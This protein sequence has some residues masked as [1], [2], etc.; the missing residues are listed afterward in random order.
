MCL[1]T[2]NLGMHLIKPQIWQHFEGWVRLWEQ[3]RSI[4]PEPLC[5]LIPGFFIFHLI[6]AARSSRAQHH[7]PALIPTK[8]LTLLAIGARFKTLKMPLCVFISH[9]FLAWDSFLPFSIPL[10]IPNQT[11]L[12]SWMWQAFWAMT[13][14]F[15]PQ[16]YNQGAIF[17]IFNI[18]SASN[19]SRAPSLR[20]HPRHSRKSLWNNLRPCLLYPQRCSRLVLPTQCSVL[21]AQCYTQRCSRPQKM[22][23]R[24]LQSSTILLITIV[25]FLVSICFVRCSLLYI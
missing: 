14:H 25:K 23:P 10:D 3:G 13:I 5:A 11:K 4:F 24:V 6:W 20:L 1:P 9:I 2:A 18:F 16:K 21:S 12:P 19:P 8:I 17:N 15:P 22:Q 7:L